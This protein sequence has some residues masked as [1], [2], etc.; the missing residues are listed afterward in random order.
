VRD[1]VPARLRPALALVD[2]RAESVLE[3]LLRLAMRRRGIDPVIP[4]FRPHPAHRVD[5]LVG[6]D[7]LVEADGEGYHDEE[8]DRIRDAFLRGLGYRVL[9]FS[10]AR[11]MH[12]M[13]A[14]LD[15][16]EAA[17]AR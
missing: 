13:D 16:I 1:A 8:K 3:T 11:I 2:P 12:E 9:R 6:S 14:V 15:E 17:L 4:Q 10:Y 5:F 7:L